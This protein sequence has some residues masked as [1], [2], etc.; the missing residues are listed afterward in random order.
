MIGRTIRRT[1]VLNSAPLAPRKLPSKRQSSWRK[2]SEFGDLLALG[3]S[4]A[5][6]PY[7]AIA[8]CLPIVALAPVRGERVG[9]P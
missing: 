2:S 9:S 6:S 7:E 5:A 8:A 3:L 1:A 4:A